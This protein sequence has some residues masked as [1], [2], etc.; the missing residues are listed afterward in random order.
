MAEIADIRNFETLE[1]W[2]RE[3]QQPQEAVVWLAHRA[4]M[5]GLPI[6]W[7]RATGRDRS[8]LPML[9]VSLTVDLAAVVHPEFLSDR[10]FRLRVTEALHQA[11]PSGIN[12]TGQI[13]DL[14]S[15]SRGPNFAS[16][17]VASASSYEP[18]DFNK[19]GLEA[20]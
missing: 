19:S 16:A 20:D 2:L 13:Q 14:S 4:V 5:R 18:A 17:C 15:F 8:P 9:R 7:N 12:S 11:E 3:T 1:A 6:F 10:N